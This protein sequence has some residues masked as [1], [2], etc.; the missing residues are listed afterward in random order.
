M[1]TRKKCKLVHAESFTSPASTDTHDPIDWSLCALCQ[2]PSSKPLNCPAKSKRTDTGAGYV[3]LGD[4]L[5]SF[6]QL[7]KRPLPIDIARLDEGDGIGSTLARNHAQWHTSCR[8]KCSA[9]R[10]ARAEV[11]AGPSGTCSD[12]SGGLPYMLRQAECTNP[13]K[14][15]NCFFCGE[16]GTEATPLH[17]AMTPRIT[18]RVRQCALKIQ[19]QKLIAQLS[20]SDLVAQEAKYH[21]NCLATLYNASKR[22]TEEGEK[23]NFDSVSHGIALAELIGYIED[24]KLSVTVNDIAPVFK[25][26]DLL[27]LYTDR[28]VELGVEITGRIHSTDLKNRILANMPGLQAYKQ[29]RDVLLSFSDDVGNALRDACVDD[30]DDEAICLA[31]AAQIIRRDL[32]GVQTQFDGSSFPQGC[33]EEAVPKSLV[34]LVSMILD[35]PNITRRDGDESRQATL[36][37]AQLL[38]YNSSLR[39]RRGS[40]S[41]QHSKSR[42]TPLPIYLGMMIHGRTRKRELIDILFHL[43]LS[44]SY[45]RVLEIS[46]DTAISAAQQYESEG[47][48]CPLILRKNLFTTAAVDNLDHNPSSTT[49]HGAFHGTGIS[50]FQNRETGSDGIMRHITQM[51]PDQCL[52][53]KQIPPLPESYITLTPVTAKQDVII[54]PTQS[55]LTSDC[56]L[57]NTAIEEEKDWQNN[58]RRLLSEGVQSV[59][60]P[61]S[62]AAFHSNQEPSRD[63]EVTI[64]SLLPLFPDDSKSVAMIRHAM[65]VVQRA[66]HH[67]NPG[68]VPVL[69]VDQPLFAI[70][71]QIQWNWPNEYGEDKFVILLGGLHL[72]MASLATIGDLLDGSG[73]T[74]AL[75]QANIATPG[76]AESFLKTAH[77][78]RTRHAHQVTAS[79]LSILLHMAYDAYSWEESEPK[80]F[81]E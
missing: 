62:W 36:S 61:I 70:A 79:A 38:Q 18:H 34:S 72:E 60:D 8:L 71:K 77:V 30:C 12:A 78:T 57:V 69:T 15:S 80:S 75:A 24:T 27:K 56:E 52:Q 21:T 74:H 68:Q 39:R 49:A 28:L 17:E 53:S 46:M 48:V 10:L 54:P 6:L 3:T 45:D 35:G 42:E 20:H 33:Q 44:I 51:Q 7:G 13:P 5:T 37:I 32:I 14:E 55:T 23:E 16:V 2:E 76:T 47:V 22:K 43:G 11:T 29:G 73:W 40:T 26:A 63:F 81:D 64:G 59:D 41:I 1:S 65:D 4:N 31:K 25:L 19:D 50:L 66:V 9:S 67:L 58:T